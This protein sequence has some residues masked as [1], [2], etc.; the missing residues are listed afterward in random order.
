[1][2][3]QSE[4]LEVDFIWINRVK[5]Q[6]MQTNANLV[7]KLGEATIQLRD[8]MNLEIGDIIQLNTD[9]TMPLD[10]MVE[11]VPKFKGI[12]GLLKG[13]RAIRVTESMFDL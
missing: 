6:I 3:F 12:P 7:V 10:V 5:E 8:I 11:G 13:N 9:A 2:G 4:Q 1:M